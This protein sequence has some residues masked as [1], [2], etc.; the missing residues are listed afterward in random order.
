MKTPIA[1]KIQKYCKVRSMLEEVQLRNEFQTGFSEDPRT[2]AWTQAGQDFEKFTGMDNIRKLADIEDTTI[3]PFGKQGAAKNISDKFGFT[4]FKNLRGTKTELLEVAIAKENSKTTEE[5][6][7]H[8]YVWM[9]DIAAKIILNE[10]IYPLSGNDRNSTFWRDGGTGTI[11]TKSAKFPED[12]FFTHV[13]AGK[14]ENFIHTGNG[15]APPPNIG[16]GAVLMEHVSKVFGEYVS[17]AVAKV[18]QFATHQDNKIMLGQL[19]QSTSIV[20]LPSMLQDAMVL[21]VLDAANLKLLTKNLPEGKPE[22]AGILLP[23]DTTLGMFETSILNANLNRE[24]EVYSTDALE[25]DLTNTL[26]QISKHPGPYNVSFIRNLREAK[27]LAKKNVAKKVD[28]AHVTVCFIISNAVN[29]ITRALGGTPPATDLVKLIFGK[30]NWDN[31]RIAELK[32]A[33]PMQL[34]EKSCPVILVKSTTGIKDSAIKIEYF[35]V[36]LA[37]DTIKKQ[38]QFMVQEEGFPASLSTTVHNEMLSKVQSLGVMDKTSGKDA[39]IKEFQ[40]IRP[41][42]SSIMGADLGSNYWEQILDTCYNGDGTF[43]QG[44]F[45]VALS[46]VFWD[47]PN[48]GNVRTCFDKDLFYEGV[49]LNYVNYPN[50]PTGKRE[51][52]PETYKISRA[53]ELYVDREQTTTPGKD[54]KI[55]IDMVAHSDVVKQRTSEV[56]NNSNFMTMEEIGTSFIKELYDGVAT[57]QELAT[58]ATDKIWKVLKNIQNGFWTMDNSTILENGTLLAG[59]NPWQYMSTEAGENSVETKRL[60]KGNTKDDVIQKNRNIEIEDMVKA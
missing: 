3:S 48:G 1:D 56:F 39:Y 10:D 41:S 23:T 37:K 19:T 5:C 52:L 2:K 45:F 7:K 32:Q 60:I 14:Y 54:I 6:L 43:R 50:G 58:L 25:I 34:L 11:Y 33:F 30:L 46:P 47:K 15:S 17:N 27:D 31:D 55:P 24:G 42:M 36:N 9:S 8:P 12:V 40:T 26:N 18:S 21:G 16:A 51:V 22:T 29:K 49:E 4:L 57:Q 28:S 13:D 44:V 20:A 38:Q 53:S 35:I 59:M